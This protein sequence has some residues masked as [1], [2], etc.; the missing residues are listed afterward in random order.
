MR[1]SIALLSA[2]ASGA[3]KNSIVTGSAFS[4]ANGSRSLATQ[5]RS[6]TRAPRNSAGGHQTRTPASVAV[7]QV[8]SR[9]ASPTA[10]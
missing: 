1:S 8:A 6:L 3:G 4:A 9:P 10:H 5:P 2:R 7:A